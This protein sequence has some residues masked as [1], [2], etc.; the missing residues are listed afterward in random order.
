MVLLRYYTERFSTIFSECFWKTRAERR[1]KI[2]A[3]GL[4][5]TRNE[6]NK[7]VSRPQIVTANKT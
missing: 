4:A 7:L 6:K 2:V 3:Y 1:S 5:R